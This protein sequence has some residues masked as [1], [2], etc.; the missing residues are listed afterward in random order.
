[1]AQK[2]KSP[3]QRKVSAQTHSNVPSAQAPKEPHRR[4]S[5]SDIL[6][7]SGWR[8]VAQVA[9]SPQH[10]GSLIA[11]FG[12]LDAAQQRQLDPENARPYV[13]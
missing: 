12:N 7:G 6:S 10:R 1:M 9:Q 4:A 2:K 13:G 3:T 11:A 5:T 8:P